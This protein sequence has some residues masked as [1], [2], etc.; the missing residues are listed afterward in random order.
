MARGGGCFGAFGPH[1]ASS[2]NGAAK[3][4][5]VDSRLV[6]LSQRPLVAHVSLW[7]DS[8]LLFPVNGEGSDVKALASFGLPTGVLGHR[9]DEGNP[10]RLTGNQVIRTH[11]T[12]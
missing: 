8:L 1:R 6:L 11:I 12:V 10:L 2:T 3:T 7:T 4:E 5:G 9:P